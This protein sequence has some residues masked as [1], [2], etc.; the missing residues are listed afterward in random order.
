[1]AQDIITRFK[2]ETT[3]FDSAIKKASKELSDYSKTATQAK[4]GFNQFTKSNV[5]AARALGTMATT[6]T[7]TK[8]KL[9]ELVGAYNEGVKA[10]K[11]LSDEHKKSDWAQALA[12]SLTQ[13]QQ[14]I[15]DTKIELQ[16]LADSK[17]NAGGLFSGDKLSG[18]LQ[19]FG[20]NLMT[21]GV[22]LATSAVTGLIN[23]TGEMIRQGVELA[24]QGEG[25]R[26]AFQRLGRGDILDGLR[27]ATHGTVTDLELMKA[28]VK[29]NDF[30]L[31]LDELGTM[32]AFAQQKAKDTGQSVDFL[33]ESI[34]NGL[35]RKSLMILDNLGLSATEI[36]E[37]MKE[38][39]D[40]T[41]AVGA[42]IRDQMQ[43]AGDY[44]ETAADRALQANVSLQNKMEELGRKFA[45]VEEA[46]NQLWT[47]IK[48]GIL[49]I[50]GGPL[51][52]LLNQ[53]TEVGRMRNA[54][55]NMGGNEQVNNQLGKLRVARK[56]GSDYMTR[57]LYNDQISNYD[58]QINK[59]NEEIRKAEES[60]KTN[61]GGIAGTKG[62][63]DALEDLKAQRDALVS[64]KGE[65][66]QGAKELMKPVEVNIKTNKAIKG[67]SDLKKQL[68]ELEAQRVKAVLTGDDEQ[69]ELLTKQIN[70]TKQ[71]I[72]YL[73]PNA[74]KTS[75]KTEKTEIQK[76]EDQIKK[77]S[78]EY[79]KLGDVE[80]EASRQ[81]QE[82]I[83]KE[84]ELLQKRN[85]LLGLR[86]E[87]A[88]GRLLSNDDMKR[89]A[90][91]DIQ[92]NTKQ[93]EDLRKQ[94]TEIEGVTIDPKTV[95]ITATDEALHKLREIDGI[96]ID[97]K[98]MTVTVETADA[99]RA[100][101]GIEGVTIDPKTI[102]VNAN[103]S[104]AQQKIDE[105]KAKIAELE[106]KNINI[107]AFVESIGKPLGEGLNKTPG[108]LLKAPTTAVYEDGVMTEKA[109]PRGGL[110]LDDKATKAV[111][112]DV[113]KSTENK[114]ANIAKEAGNIA[115]GIG[116]VVGGLEQLGL[117]IP[118]GIKGAVGVLSTIM[119][120]VSGIATTVLAIE[121]LTAADSFLPF[122]R[123]GIVPH[124]AGG[125]F[126]GGSHYSGDVTPIMANA[127]ELV[128]NRAQQFNLASQLEG[129][130]MQGL[131]LTA[132]IRG[133]QIRLALNNNGRRTGKGE[134]V[135]TNRR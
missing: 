74:L 90:E 14:R 70:T 20:G 112:K 13:L 102:E 2:L 118:E 57:S 119:T 103:T 53:L 51:A 38:T 45:P 3:A 11:A 30:K 6:S 101:Q 97:D 19:V 89:K 63:N 32:L 91:I 60:K 117:D 42:I 71:K 96:T 109:V 75:G 99:L 29:F 100:L 36:R 123:G 44:V 10:Y 82:E 4:E 43:Q 9:Q 33:V 114:T 68:K 79:A 55:N 131:N 107:Q 56:N 1:M 50:I 69:V 62:I 135:Q 24:R 84:I 54:L 28:A 8:Q 47:S 85:G 52:T 86:A 108:T 106:D 15:K 22:E 7:N 128:L 110:Q 77:L 5:D 111:M 58:Q 98:T 94:L 31:P 122:A 18:M 81:R 37:R 130:G 93:I 132:T 23:E 48:I 72:G 83:K 49:D 65:Y 115:S 39:G 34:V 25:I 127:G 133:E 59:L 67:I 26:I 46:S 121:A 88:Q 27:E 64:M 41:K 113:N 66:V 21:K 87:Q 124:A 12:G 104:E 80:T 116:S 35:G 40:M 78:L 120:I 16:G 61:I 126:V 17:G 105:L 95:T 76:N 92:A 134:Y 125:Y 129:N 73:D